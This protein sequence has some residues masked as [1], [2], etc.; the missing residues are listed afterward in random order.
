MRKALAGYVILLVPQG[1]SLVFNILKQIIVAGGS[2]ATLG[3]AAWQMEGIALGYQFGSLLLPTLAPV[4]LW[5]WFDRAFF[6]SIIVEG[7]LE[8]Q[9]GRADG[10]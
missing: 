3:A 7:W 10:G 2:P 5:L 9:V 6:S 1:F 4:L 8:Q